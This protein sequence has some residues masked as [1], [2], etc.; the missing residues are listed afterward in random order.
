MKKNE[1]IALMIS[2]TVMQTIA[3][4]LSFIPKW[5]GNWEGYNTYYNLYDGRKRFTHLLRLTSGISQKVLCE[6]LKDLENDN[7]IGKEYFY[8]YP[9]RV[10]YFLTN[11]GYK[12]A[13]LLKE[14]QKLG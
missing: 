8:E 1:K 6:N 10:E 5:C 7:L 14:F 13:K 9:P 11:K 2:V 4:I 12:Y 3:L